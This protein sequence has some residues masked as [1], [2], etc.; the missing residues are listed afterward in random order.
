MAKAHSVRKATPL[1]KQ[2]KPEVV[3]AEFIYAPMYGTRLSNLESLVAGIQMYCPEAKL[4]IF[5]DK[6]DEARLQRLRESVE[7]P[8]CLS[9]PIDEVA[10]EKALP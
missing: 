9:F 3:I 8:V 4:I 6:S 2:L 5:Y 7:L 1:L 10:L